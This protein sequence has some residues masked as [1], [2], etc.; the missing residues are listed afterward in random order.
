MNFD[1]R[2]DEA[3]FRSTVRAWLDENAPRDLEAELRAADFGQSQLKDARMLAASKAWQRAKFDAGW[4]CLDWPRAYGGREASPIERIIW[5]QEEG[6]YAA[7]SGV[8]VL[9]HGMCGPTLMHH[10][11]E[12][13]RRRLLPRIASGDDI[14]CQL[15]SEPS[16]G[17]D[18]AAVRTRAVPDGDSWVVNG[19]KV[20]TSYAQYAD[21]GLLLAR[22][23]PTVP[24][25][26][27]L[28]MFLL[29]MRSAGVEVRPIRQ[30]N[31][32][33]DFNEVF[34]SDVR[35]PDSQ[36]L[37][38]VGEGWRVAL[39]TLM[40]ERLAVGSVMPTGFPQ[41]VALARVLGTIDDPSFQARIAACA[42]RAYGL[43]N[44][45]LR[46]V[47]AISKGE[48][49]GPE[50]S[51]GK[52]VAGQTLQETAALALDMMGALGAISGSEGVAGGYFQSMLLRSPAVRIE[53]G[54]DEI[55]RNVIGERVLGLPADIRVDKDIPFDRI[56]ISAL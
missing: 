46:A 45:G 22:T 17:S 53:G 40:N 43:R 50:N 47:S 16:G 29:D 37:G 28:T 31:G 27:G 26:R 52:L 49:P 48:E 56:P 14:W 19:Q 4:A 8:F 3:A 2:P 9:G 32:G 12:A 6:V 20:W 42:V 11:D 1:D 7:L 35:I 23:D 44:T 24:K 13:T 5:D 38:G 55:L 51:I 41:L 54:T 21:Y 36:R 39:T 33:S 10:A 15:F 18:L 25:H 30:A 34:F